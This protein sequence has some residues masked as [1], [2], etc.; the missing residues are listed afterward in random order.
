MGKNWCE[1]IYSSLIQMI[2]ILKKCR[3]MMEFFQISKIPK[4]N[5]NTRNRSRTTPIC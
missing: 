3:V 4:L 1:N 2:I 5:F